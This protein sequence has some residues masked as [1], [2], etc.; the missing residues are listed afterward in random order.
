MGVACGEQKLTAVNAEPDVDIASHEDGTVVGEGML[1][2]ILAVVD[3]ADDAEENLIATWTAGER[4]VCEATPVSDFGETVC[5]MRLSEREE[6]VTVLVQDPRGSTGADAVRLDVAPTD[7]PVINLL[8]PLASGRYYSSLGVEVVAEVSDSEDLAAD[9]VVEWTL[10][11]ASLETPAE[12][13]DLPRTPDADGRVG[14]FLDLEEGI[15][16]IGAS[17]TDTTD[18]TTS[19]GVQITVGGPNRSP[20]CE[21]VSPDDGLVWTADAPI[22]LT[23]IVGDEDWPGEANKLSVQWVSDVDDLIGESTPEG[24]GGVTL[25]ASS[26]S[27]SP[28]TLTLIAE[29]DVGSTCAVERSVIITTRPEVELVKPRGEVLYYVDHPVELEGV[30]TD[31][32]DAAGAL[33][34]AWAS[35]ADGALTVSPDLDASGRTL[36]SVMLSEGPHT[37]TLTGTDADGVTGSDTSTIVVRG[38]N[39]PPSCA[40]TSPASGA[41]G[42]EGLTSTFLGTVDDTDIGPEALTVS[43]SSDVDGALGESA[44]GSDGF[45]TISSSALSIATH[46]ISMTVS[47]EVGAVCVDDI[48]FIVGR[49]PVVSIASPADGSVANSGEVVTFLGSATDADEAETALSV[50]WVSDLDGVLFTGSP[51]SSGLTLTTTAALA[52]GDHTV[53]L[54]ATDSLGLMSTAVTVFRVNALPTTPVVRISP[55]PAKT[56]DTLSVVIDVD[57]VDLESDPITYRTEWFRDGVLVSEAGTVPPDDTAKHQVWEVRLTPTDGYG[58]GIGGTATRT[59][60][61]TIPVIHSVTITPDSVYTDTVATAVVDATDADEDSLSFT[62]AWTVNTLPAGDEGGTL[63]GADAFVKHD[64]VQVSVIPSDGESVGEAVEASAVVV[65]N[66]PPSA[67]I[68]AIAPE[69]PVGGMDTLQ[70]TIEAPGEDPDGDPVLYTLSW[71]REGEAYPD[72]EHE[73]TGILWSGPLTDEWT[74]DTVPA[75]DTTPDEDWQCTV[76]SWDDEEMGE[77]AV[78]EVTLAAPPPGCGDGILQAGEEY[79]PAPGPF[80][81]VSVDSETCRWDF[82][83]VEQLYCYGLCSWAG[84]PGCDAS[85]ADVLCK[86]ITDNPD[87][88]AISYTVTAPLSA[89]G[90]PGIYCGFG[91]LIYTDRGVPDVGWMD[92]SMAAHHGGG[93]EV[94]AF[95][96]CTDP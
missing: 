68:I 10:Q 28:H 23:G 59:I 74:D 88:E 76:T 2:T 85:D 62:H 50:E 9:L 75:A 77:S 95:P 22:T 78:A 4:T 93:G 20:S 72:V 43:W 63:D 32:E 90:F 45:V 24:D 21:W 64:V 12:S 61:N 7:A 91:D 14:G 29:D 35:D 11:N 44:P 73:D 53:T 83:E 5:S 33:A 3:D 69:D 67:P 84:P 52:V 41:G 71:E 1:V 48:V 34:A 6:T 82:S 66:A 15:W 79:D 39:Q 65:Q 96:D 27:V 36:G 49:P 37:L 87:S 38:P 58:D 86:L 81:N 17:V 54:T 94:V 89:P 92:E 13:V 18:K 55:D 40:I 30:I 25:T 8:A 26:L 70:C 46:T 57:S 60:D 31:A 47:D 56:T 51:D 42:G 19:T 16:N 80:M